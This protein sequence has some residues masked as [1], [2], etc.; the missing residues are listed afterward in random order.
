MGSVVPEKA[1]PQPLVAE[2][3]QKEM[4]R[5]QVLPAPPGKGSQRLALVGQPVEMGILE[6]AL[7]SSVAVCFGVLESVAGSLVEDPP[8]QR[9]VGISEG[10]QR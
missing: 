1:S 6:E 8:S 9:L 5:R 7:Q 10:I 4:P 2:L 3:Q